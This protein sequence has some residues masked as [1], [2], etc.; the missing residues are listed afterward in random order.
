LDP[1]G[2]HLNHG[3]FGAVPRA[4]TEAA[5]RLPAPVE[6]DRNASIATTSTSRS[7]W[8][9]ARRN[10]FS[11][12]SRRARHERDE[13]AVVVFE[14]LGLLAGDEIVLSDHAYPHV[15]DSARRAAARAGRRFARSS[16]RNASTPRRSSSGSR[17]R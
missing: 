1:D 15:A 8:P 17:Q 7:T 2:A 6:T 5:R 3:S 16:C 12:T 4:V 10:R 13:A 14:A 11:A 9:V